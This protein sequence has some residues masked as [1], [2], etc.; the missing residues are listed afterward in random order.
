MVE[1]GVDPHPQATD[2]VEDPRAI[3]QRAQARFET[4]R[5]ANLPYSRGGGS[6][7]CQERVGRFCYWYDEEGDNAPPIL[8]RTD[9]SAAAKPHH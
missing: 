9:L 7:R 3:G 8:L 1:S 2:A 6:D 5:R 4:F